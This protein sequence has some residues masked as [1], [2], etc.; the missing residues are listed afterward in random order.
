VLREALKIFPDLGGATSAFK[1]I[2]IR[3]LAAKAQWPS[4]PPQDPENAGSNPESRFWGNPSSA[5]V[6]KTTVEGRNKCI[7]HHKIKINKIKLIFLKNL[8][9]SVHTSRRRLDGQ[10]SFAN[11]KSGDPVQVEPRSVQ[12]LE[13]K[14]FP[15]R[16]KLIFN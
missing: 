5:V 14:K 16:Q 7:G 13:K 4:H 15:A 9:K 11:Q 3:A 12:R 6:Y 1:K 10:R 2:K 8:L